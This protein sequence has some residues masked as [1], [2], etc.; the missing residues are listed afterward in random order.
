MFGKLFTD[1][2]TV[3]ELDRFM[4][5]E[6][7]SDAG[8]AGDR[9]GGGVRGPWPPGGAPEGPGPGGGGLLH[10]A[11]A[12]GRGSG[13]PGCRGGHDGRR[14]PARNPQIAGST[15]WPGRRPP[16][17]SWLPHGQ[18]HRKADPPAVADL[19]PDGRAAPD[20]G[21]RDPPGRRGL[22]PDDQ[23][24]GVQP[25]L[26]RRP[27]RAVVAGHRAEDR[28]AERG[29]LR[30]GDLHAAA[31]ELLPPGDRVLRPGARRPAHGADPARRRVRLRRAAAAGAAAAVVGQALAAVGAR[32]AVGASW[33]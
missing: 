11:Q 24:R 12:D 29:L 7:R 14:Q 2:A 18:G 23:R 5:H 6:H 28:E 31:R 1:R 25:A 32:A 19:V 15:R 8:R 26:L 10:L 4:E 13:R 17:V 33:P 16:R 30:G 20:L 21:A 3:P 27:R 9:S 22:R